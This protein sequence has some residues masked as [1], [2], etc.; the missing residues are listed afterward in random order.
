MDMSSKRIQGNPDLRKG[1]GSKTT[2]S[3]KIMEDP[4]AGDWLDCKSSPLYST[5]T[6]GARDI[7][8]SHAM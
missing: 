7:V 2:D 3:E 6:V 5:E 4:P 1:L 8:P